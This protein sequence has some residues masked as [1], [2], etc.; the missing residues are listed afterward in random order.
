M[1]DLIVSQWSALPTGLLQESFVARMDSR[2]EQAYTDCIR[3][4]EA[5]PVRAG[6]ALAPH[7]L[8]QA[9]LPAYL[10]PYASDSAAPPTACDWPFCCAEHQPGQGGPAVRELVPPA[11]RAAAA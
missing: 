7:R 4:D 8:P 9:A 10:A 3:L 2:I 11:P 1:M 6:P 5:G